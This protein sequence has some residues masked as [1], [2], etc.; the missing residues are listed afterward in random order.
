MK[1]WEFSRL[2]IKLQKLRQQDDAQPGVF[3]YRDV[4]GDNKIDINDRTF[5]GDPNPDFTYGINIAASYKNFDFSAFFFGSQGN[6]I[7]NNTLYFTDF[8]DFFK[9]GLRREAAVNSWTPQNP[10]AKVPILRNTGGFSTDN[11]G[12][13]NSYF[14]SDGSYFRSK[15]MQIGYTFPGNKLSKWG[16]DRLRVYVQGANLFTLTSY[17]GLD[18]EL[19]S[20]PD[21]GNV[22]TIPSTFMFGIDQGNYPHTPTYLFGLN[23]NF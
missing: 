10:N 2:P 1:Y 8:P 12:F 16:I 15:Q 9:G 22:G 23:L 7:F 5:I 19:S 11:S 14:I 13:A 17:E 4:N 20:Q 6:D 3:Q 21:Q 18:P